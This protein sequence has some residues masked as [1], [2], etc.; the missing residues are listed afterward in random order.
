MSNFHRIIWIDRQIRKRRYPNREQIAD[1]FEISVRQAARDIEYMRDSMGAPI[2]Y[3]ASKRGYHYRD[4]TYI[5]PTQYIT[6][7]DKELL[8]Y[9]ANQYSSYNYGHAAHLAELFH[10][11]AEGGHT[12][13]PNSL[14]VPIFDLCEVERERLKLLIRGIEERLKVKLCYINQK[15]QKKEEVF[16]PYK[17]IIKDAKS[18]LV[19]VDEEN[20]I[21]TI[22]VDRIKKVEEVNQIFDIIAYYD[23]DKYD[24]QVLF[25]MSNPYEARIKLANP[26]DITHISFYSERISSGEYIVKFYHSQKLLSELLAYGGYFQ[27]KSPEWLKDKLKKR[28][29]RLLDGQK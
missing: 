14:E 11:L 16:C 27:I 8:G 17:L 4:E 2:E 13:H 15:Y 20:S 28:L 1:R 6:D 29:R 9:L 10:R 22:R 3:D 25:N 19:G 18:Y 12:N 7:K 23:E 5:L 26:Q 21:Q 24:N